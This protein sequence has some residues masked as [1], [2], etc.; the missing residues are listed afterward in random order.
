MPLTVQTGL[1]KQR[2]GRRG[3]RGRE[4]GNKGPRKGVILSLLGVSAPKVLMMIWLILGIIL[5]E[6][7]TV[8]VEIIAKGII[9]AE[10]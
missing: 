1:R 4:V 5:M 9:V 10:E 6:V 8:P 7:I 2:C 3:K